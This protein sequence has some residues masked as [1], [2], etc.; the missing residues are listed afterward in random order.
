M[1]KA[2]GFPSSD[3]HMTVGW[4]VR[5]SQNLPSR[6]SGL[7]CPPR[8]TT[9]SPAAVL[10]AGPLAIGTNQG[11]HTCSSLNVLPTRAF[12]GGT[13]RTFSCEGA[14]PIYSTGVL[15]ATFSP[16]GG[17]AI[18]MA[19]ARG[20]RRSTRKVRKGGPSPGVVRPVALLEAHH[21]EAR[22]RQP[23]RRHRTRGAGPNDEYVHRRLLYTS[24]TD[25]NH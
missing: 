11:S 20:L 2:R 3:T 15:P 13:P 19:K 23:H 21:A 17:A 25:A 10:L 4:V 12:P 14:P 5:A 8:A 9:A 7:T 22:L 16:A 1:A 6:R 18:P 24:S